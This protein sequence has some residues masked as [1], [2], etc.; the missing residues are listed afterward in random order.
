MERV[1][2]FDSVPL[3]APISPVVK[4]TYDEAL[5][6]S[7]E[8]KQHYFLHA[9]IEVDG[10][11]K[12]SKFVDALLDRGKRRLRPGGL[13]VIGEGGV[14]KSFVLN[15]IYERYPYLDTSIARI[16]PLICLS[17]RGRPAA[18]DL[19]CTMLLQLGQDPDLMKNRNN[20]DLEDN[21]IESLKSCGT[22]GVLFDE[23]HHLWL[24]SSGR[25]I[26]DR[27]GGPIGDLLKRVYDATNIA[28][29]FS[30]TPG[31]MNSVFIDRQVSTRWSGVVTL[32]EFALDEK[33]Y[34]LLR[35]LDAAI[36]L[37]QPAGLGTTKRL[38]ENVYAS[39][40]GNFRLIKN[41]LAEAIFI[42]A[43]DG[44]VKL[45]KRHLAESHF[46]MFC[47]RENPFV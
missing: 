16:T 1:D 20:D 31:L 25:K 8:Q 29:I 44:S 35:A 18:S 27:V 46:R 17:F 10:L 34:G 5:K 6:G 40:S 42:A 3:D 41:L 36:P 30:G 43:E 45:E 4:V 33:F 23:A 14:G 11:A 26:K 15:D 32:K 39:T 2:L 22:L 47:D 37:P 13:W 21:L 38:T 19:M 9:K 24:N 7:S 12:A 28:Y